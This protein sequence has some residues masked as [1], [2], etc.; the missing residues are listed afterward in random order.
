MIEVIIVLEEEVFVVHVAKCWPW[1]HQRKR[2]AARV[3]AAAA[4]K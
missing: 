4:A 3:V 2:R 1:G